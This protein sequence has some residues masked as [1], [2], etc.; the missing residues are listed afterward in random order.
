[1]PDE[2][3]ARAV[4]AMARAMR[5]DAEN[6]RDDWGRDEGLNDAWRSSGRAALSALHALPSADRLAL[7]RAL[8][9]EGW[10]AAPTK[11]SDAMKRRVLDAGGPQALAWAVAAWPDMLAA[12]DAEARG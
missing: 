4:E 3:T 5:R 10:Q 2:A 1:M 8:M 7:A 6:G 11:V 9:P 12:S